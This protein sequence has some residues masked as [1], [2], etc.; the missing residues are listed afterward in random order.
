MSRRD[1]WRIPARRSSNASPAPVPGAITTHGVPAG[2]LP[3]AVAVRTH[4]HPL[5]SKSPSSGCGCPGRPGVVPPSQ[6]DGRVTSGDRLQVSASAGTCSPRSAARSGNLRLRA[7]RAARR[8]R[9]PTKRSFGVRRISTDKSPPFENALVR[10]R[11]GTPPARV[12]APAGPP[13]RTRPA[14]SPP[15]RPVRTG[16]RPP[17]GAA[18]TGPEFPFPHLGSGY[19][20]AGPGCAAPTGSGRLRSEGGDSDRGLPDVPTTPCGIPDAPRFPTHFGH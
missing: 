18:A 12:R 17:R 10:T 13:L 20:P 14:S 4:R 7:C 9:R 6:R 5:K 16:R 3:P 15:G 11:A 2:A 8:S 19:F 1:R